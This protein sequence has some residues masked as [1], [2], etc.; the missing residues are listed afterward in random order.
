MIDRYTVIWNLVQKHGYRFDYRTV[1]D[2]QNVNSKI[3]YICDKH[4]LVSQFYSNHLKGK[5]CLKCSYEERYRTKN[6]IMTVEK[7]IQKCKDNNI[8]ISKFDLSNSVITI[9]GKQ[10]THISVKCKVCGYEWNPN[11]S[12][13][14]KGHGCPKCY[15]RNKTD[16]EVREELSKL[17]PELDFS[18]TKY[19]ERDKLDR[20]KVICPKHGEQLINYNNLKHG[21]GCYFCGR[22]K[23]TEKNKYTKEEFIEMAFKTHSLD[24]VDYTNTIYKG[25]RYNVNVFCKHCGKEYTQ[26]A[27]NHLKGCGCQRCAMKKRN[28]SETLFYNK[29]KEI[30]PDSIHGYRD[31]KIFGK[32]SLD[33]YIP[34]LNVGIEFQGSQHFEEEHFNKVDSLEV[35]IRRDLNKIRICKENNIKLYHFTTFKVPKDFK[36]YKIYTDFD[37]LIQ[38]IKE[39]NQL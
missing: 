28:K 27:M 3:T 21:Q 5:I 37:E 2:I 36:L 17:H 8:D 35:N 32:Q 10:Q 34:S 12:T 26:L 15:G 13:F 16:E 24:D 9:D 7:V 38:K 22:E 23:A 1:N 31:K 39:D 18:E 29:V 33:I 14:T 20:I 30:F 6:R 4:G 25:L 11:T 19:S